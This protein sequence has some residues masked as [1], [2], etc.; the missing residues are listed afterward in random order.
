VRAQVQAL[1][2][3]PGSYGRTRNSG[4]I[5]HPQRRTRRRSGGLWPS[6]SGF[7]HSP[8]RLVIGFRA[9]AETEYPVN[10]RRAFRRESVPQGPCRAFLEAGAG[11][12]IDGEG[13]RALRLRARRSCA[14]A[15]KAPGRRGMRLGPAMRRERLQPQVSYCPRPAAALRH[16]PDRRG[17]WPCRGRPA[18]AR[19]GGGRGRE[20]RKTG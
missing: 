16:P 2:V 13:T 3:A 7:A 15:P 1:S 19:R 12:A 8:H 10:D 4:T 11:S 18:R 17:A 9:A 20:S 5:A 14:P 6:A